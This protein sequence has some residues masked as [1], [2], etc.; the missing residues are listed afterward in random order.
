MPS[1]TPG[2]LLLSLLGLLV[3]GCSKR[4]AEDVPILGQLPEFSL[5]DQ[6]QKAFARETME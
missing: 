5:L 1:K 3:L 4:T 2:L 6:D